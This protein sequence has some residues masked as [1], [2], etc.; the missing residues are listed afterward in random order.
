LDGFENKTNHFITPLIRPLI[1]DPPGAWEVCLIEAFYP[2]SWYNISSTETD[3]TFALV[4]DDRTREVEIDAALRRKVIHDGI[5]HHVPEGHYTDPG[6]LLRN[7]WAH[8]PSNMSCS[9]H[10]NG[11]DRKVSITLDKWEAI[12][13][14]HTL[15]EVLGFEKNTLGPV[16]RAKE[17]HVYTSDRPISLRHTFHLF[18]YIDI[19]EPSLVGHTEAQLLAVIPLDQGKNRSWGDSCFFSIQ[20]PQ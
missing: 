11:A 17:N 4:P 1:F 10:I 19:V 14:N 18:I 20:N 12:R 3:F 2:Y 13:F 8:N 5:N 9:Y 7:I 15:A 6:L 16:T